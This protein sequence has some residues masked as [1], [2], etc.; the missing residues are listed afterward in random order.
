MCALRCA[1][2]LRGARADKR[3]LAQTLMQSNPTSKVLAFKNKPAP[4]TAVESSLRVLY[5]QNREAPMLPKKRHIPQAPERILESPEL[6]DD[7]HLD[8]LDWSSTN[9]VGVALGD[10]IWMWNAANGAVQKLMSTQGEGSHVTSL[11]WVQQGNIMAVGTSDNKVQIWDVEKLRQVRSMDG[12]R[13]RVSSLAWNGP[14]L[15]SGG[16]DSTI[17]HHDVRQQ[18]HKVGTLRG[19]TQEV[20]GLKWSPSGTFLASGGNDNLLNIWDGRFTREAGQTCETPLHRL[21]A[22][23]AAVKALAWCPSQRHL[24][25]SGGGTADRMIRLWNACS[26]AMLNEVGTNSQVCSLQWSQHD[27]ELVSSHGFPHNQLILWKYPLMV[28]AAELT[29]HT[30]RVLHMTQSP[31]G[32]TI[33][34]AA[35]DETLRF[36]KILSGGKHQR[37][38]AKA[39]EESALFNHAMMIR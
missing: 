25:A 22:H 12:H 5:T 21:E 20:C 2:S 11:S 19:H 8:L 30:G 9:V 4:S 7:D 15:S 37:K 23:Q 3:K 26:G 35:A 10:S 32:T 24:L 33:C 31:D 13:E 17:V 39:A 14:I 34:S 29:G 36:W 18:Q 6:L 1:R 28:K 16:R 27:K 38:V